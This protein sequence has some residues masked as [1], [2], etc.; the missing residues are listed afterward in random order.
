MKNLVMA[1]K[2]EWGITPP[3]PTVKDYGIENINRAYYKL[4]RQA[5]KKGFKF[6]TADFRWYKNGRFTKGWIVKGNKWEQRF[7][8]KPDVIF[9]KTKL[10]PGN[11]KYKKY[12]SKKKM[13]LNPYSI[14]KICNDKM[15]TYRLFKS[16]VPKLFLV[17][18]KKQL[19]EKLDKIKTELVVVK[20]R[21]GSSAKGLHICTKKQALRLKIKEDY[22]L[23][24]FIDTRKGLKGLSKGVYDIRVIMAGGKFTYAWMRK[25]EK[26]LIS[27]ISRGGKL[28]LLKRKQI[29]KQILKAARQID[30]KIR[31]HKPRIY[32][33]DFVLDEKGKPKLIELNSKPGFY[34]FKE[35][36]VNAMFDALKK[37]AK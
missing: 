22:L 36:V 16:L 15:L 19:K 23:Q 6:Y 29:P 18:N 3:W 5:A 21:I 7:N 24:E 2:N 31:K 33:A 8:I 9:D 35:K 30:N 26:S 28:V 34:F 17:K 13:I 20:P 25:A 37:A 1:Y 11:I 4:A 32:T 12:F 27:N 10:S 14:E